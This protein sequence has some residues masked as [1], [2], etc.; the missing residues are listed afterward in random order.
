MEVQR[1]HFEPPKES[2]FNGG[3]KYAGGKRAR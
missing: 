3:S 2:G 1:K